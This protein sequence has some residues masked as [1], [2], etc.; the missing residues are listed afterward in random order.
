MGI[1]DLSE[2]RLSC[3]QAAFAARVGAEPRDAL[4]SAVE[5]RV[6]VYVAEADR[7]IRYELDRD[8]SVLRGDV[9]RRDSGAEAP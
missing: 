4:D 8:G 3:G 7:T 6:F 1:L 2:C 5:G 9:F